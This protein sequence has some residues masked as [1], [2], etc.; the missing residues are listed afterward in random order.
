MFQTKL[1]NYAQHLP[2]LNE[3]GVRYNP[4]IFS[5][6]GRIHLDA[7]ATL[8]SI[9]V[10][11][12]SRREFLD[13][14]LL[15]RRA[16]AVIGVQIWRRAARMVK[17]CLPK[18]SKEECNLLFSLVRTQLPKRWLM[19]RASVTMVKGISTWALTRPCTWATAT[20]HST[21]LHE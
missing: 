14:K 21:F 3:N 12:A 16:H 15:L 9:V 2:H 4:L 10:R 1:N 8:E 11:A 18:L 20:D 6:Y 5:C 7:I 13:H 19:R 17:V